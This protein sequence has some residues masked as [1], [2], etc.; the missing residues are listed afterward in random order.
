MLNHLKS[1][2]RYFQTRYPLLLFPGV[3]YQRRC[4]GIIFI[5]SYPSHETQPSR[6]T[7]VKLPFVIRTYDLSMTMADVSDKESRYMKPNI[8]AGSIGRQPGIDGLAH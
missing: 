7:L 4:N 1:N 5:I 2:P 6:H 8:F 3:G